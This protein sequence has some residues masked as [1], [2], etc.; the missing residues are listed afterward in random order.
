MTLKIKCNHSILV[1][2]RHFLALACRLKWIDKKFVCILLSCYIKSQGRTILNN[3]LNCAYHNQQEQIYTAQYQRHLLFE[4][5]CVL[6]KTQINCQAKN[7]QFILG[8]LHCDRGSRLSMSHL[9]WMLIKSV[10]AP[11]GLLV[12]HIHS[13][14]Y[15]IKTPSLH[16]YQS[17]IIK[18]TCET[19]KS[20]LKPNRKPISRSHVR[21]ATRHRRRRKKT[22]G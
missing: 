1:K 11:S 15:C 8:I 17:D 7:Y 19:R 18:Y 4:S 20:N 3:F 21:H 14:F 6:S 2:R 5:E 10:P 16:I 13:P 12:C 9:R 22:R